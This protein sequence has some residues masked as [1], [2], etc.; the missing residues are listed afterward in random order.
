MYSMLML[1]TVGSFANNIIPQKENSRDFQSFFAKRNLMNAS[2]SAL[3]KSSGKHFSFIQRLGIKHAQHQIKKEFKKRNLL[4]GCDTLLLKNGDSIFAIVSQVGT[5][6]ITYK[7]CN[8]QTGANYVVKKSDVASIHFANGSI[9]Y[10]Q[11]RGGNYIEE[12]AV[13]TEMVTTDPMA[14]ASFVSSGLAA[15]LLLVSGAGLGLIGL[16][17]LVGG[18]VTGF[19]SRK[20]IKDSKG[21]LKGKGL[22]NAGII[23][24]FSLLLLFLLLIVLVVI[25]IAIP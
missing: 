5:S 10:L 25:L 11:N 12:R 15:L 16:G 3:E 6:E 21:K 7:N 14:I 8:N 22:A 2:I 13:N 24:G 1:I 17:L 23:I 19:M 9:D 20:R 18:I 4:S